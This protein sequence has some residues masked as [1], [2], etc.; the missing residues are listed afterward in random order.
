M[1][2]NFQELLPDE[3]A[4]NGAKQTNAA[5][6]RAILLNAITT[7]ALVSGTR[8]IE[9]EL[10]TALQ[11]S[12]TPLREALSGLRAEQLLEH[13][14]DGLR[15]RQLGWGDVRQLYDMRSTLEGMAARLAA[16][17]SSDSEK[18]VIS[19]LCAKEGQL[20]DDG[21]RPLALA[22]HNKRFHNAILKSAGNQ[23]LS[24]ELTRLS[25]LT[26][27]LGTTV[28]SLPDRLPAIRAEHQN[29]N[30][31]IGAGDGTKAEAMMRL[32]LENGLQARL[33]IMSLTDG[34]ELD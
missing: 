22:Q 25:R 31:A 27:L 30:Q 5:R 24:D 20:I 9:T 16:T 34:Q 11:V 10:G 19:D 3:G 15:V 26:I 8:I 33:L 13:D 14:G 21:A 1:M 17:T 12:R 28:Y 4:H 7:G 18:A 29:I 32:H 2:I 6:I 23:F